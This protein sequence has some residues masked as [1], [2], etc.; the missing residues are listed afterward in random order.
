VR[1]VEVNTGGMRKE[2]RVDQG[3]FGLLVGLM[4][5]A[6][7]TVSTLLTRRADRRRV[8][9]MKKVSPDNDHPGVISFA[10]G[11]RSAFVMLCFI[12]GVVSIV[13]SFFM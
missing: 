7:G 2:A 10:Q 5:I 8:E 9:L 3:T 12:L 1:Y 6:V 4:L 11:S 13:S